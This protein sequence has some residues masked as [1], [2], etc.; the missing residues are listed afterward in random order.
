MKRLVATTHIEVVWIEG[1]VN[2]RVVFEP[3]DVVSGI[4]ASQ[5]ARLRA[6]GAVAEARKEKE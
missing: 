6:R 1:S 2:K 5:L 4:P 3:G